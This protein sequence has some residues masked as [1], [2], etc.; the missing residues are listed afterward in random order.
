M[1]QKILILGATGFTG[2]PIAKQLQKDG[3]SIRILV[4]NA[5]KARQLFGKDI[6]VIEGS[7]EDTATLSRAL[8]GCSGVNLS[9]PWKVERQVTQSLIDILAKQGRKDVQIAYLSGISV[10]PENRWYA[11]IDE[12]AKTEALLEQSNLPYTIFKPNWFMDALKLFVR[13]V[14]ATICGKQTLAYDFV[15]LEDYAVLVSKAF[16]TAAAHRQKIVVNGPQALLMAD[17]LQKYCDAVEP[18]MK[19]SVMPIWFGKM[20]GLLTGSAE[21]K[22]AVAMMAYFEKVQH[23]ASP[24]K[25]AILGTAS[26]TFD[27]WLKRQSH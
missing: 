15:A 12:K 20:L 17:A 27:E 2:T 6:D 10:I 25:T 7:A 16:Q 19:A 24:D 11:M 22:D 13:D 1:T 14:R 9:L 5:A 23:L 21:L 26:L 18:G 4:R 3:F 8:E